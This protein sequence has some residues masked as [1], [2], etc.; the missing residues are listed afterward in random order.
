[1]SLLIKHGIVLYLKGNNNNV[2]L[3]NCSM[4][5]NKHCKKPVIKF[6]IS[7]ETNESLPKY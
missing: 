1:M 7:G 4:Y 2:A 5:M 6:S 3:H